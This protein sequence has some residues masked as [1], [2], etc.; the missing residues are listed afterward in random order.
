MGREEKMAST[1]FV[2]ASVCRATYG[3]AVGWVAFIFLVPHHE[4][5]YFNGMIAHLEATVVICM[6][7]FSHGNTSLY[8]P[9]WCVL[10]IAV[11]AGWM[12]TAPTYPSLRSL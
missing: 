11:A 2:P 1:Q 7:S 5:P 6:F 3:V 8:D 10:P 4:D 12:C 9:A